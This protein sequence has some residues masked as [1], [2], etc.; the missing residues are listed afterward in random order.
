MSPQLVLAIINQFT[1]SSCSYSFTMSQSFSSQ[2]IFFL[3]DN[4]IKLK[5]LVILGLYVLTL[6]DLSSGYSFFLELLSF[7]GRQ[8]N[9]TLS[10]IH[11]LRSRVQDYCCHHMQNLVNKLPFSRL[12]H[13]L[14]LIYK[15]ILW[16]SIYQ[17]HCNEC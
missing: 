15:F 2:G 8:W 5:H 4:D 1:S 14:D 13:H 16:P 17:S 6:I 7:C 12:W 3:V 9:K 11:L 10:C